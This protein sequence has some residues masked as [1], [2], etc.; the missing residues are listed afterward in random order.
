[1]AQGYY[2]L[3]T[4]YPTQTGAMP[5]LFAI[6]DGIPFAWEGVLIA[7][8]VLLFAGNYFIIKSKT[9]REKILTA[10]VSSSFFMI[11]LSS[12]FALA[13][14]VTYIMVLFWAFLLIIAFIMLEVSDNS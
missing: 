2:N 14:L 7:V 9:G 10:L 5:L 12:L 1:M 3:T 6:R 4:D 13:Q 11:V 8:F